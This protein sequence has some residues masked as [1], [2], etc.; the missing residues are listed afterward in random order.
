MYSLKMSADNDDDES[1]YWPYR[2][3]AKL[4]ALHYPA[5]PC[6]GEGEIIC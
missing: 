1:E 4:I 2:I 3:P 5:A 6:C